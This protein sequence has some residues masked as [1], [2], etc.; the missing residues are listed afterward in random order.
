[1]EPVMNAGVAQF[2]AC[3][4]GIK[5]GTRLNFEHPLLNL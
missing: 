5:F 4:I 3:L 2:L 1:M